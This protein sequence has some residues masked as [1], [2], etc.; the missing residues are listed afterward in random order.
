MHLG[1]EVNARFNDALSGTDQD[2]MIVPGVYAG[3]EF[4]AFELQIGSSYPYFMSAG[5]KVPIVH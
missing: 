1:L 3:Y 5:I 2:F 4:G